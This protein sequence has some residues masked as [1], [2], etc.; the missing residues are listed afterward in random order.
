MNPLFAELIVRERMKE[1]LR[2][3]E[4]ARLAQASIPK[5]EKLTL[6]QRGLVW[7]GY[8][9]TATGSYLLENYTSRDE[10]SPDHKQLLEMSIGDLECLHR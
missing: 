4:L 9:L 7:L 6:H 3:A 10:I 5:R 2:E 1:R 8:R